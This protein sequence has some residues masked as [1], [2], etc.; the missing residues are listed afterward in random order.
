MSTVRIT[1]VPSTLLGQKRRA[2]IEHD[3]GR[4][5]AALKRVR[6]CC[7]HERE[8]SEQRDGAHLVAAMGADE[9]RE[10]EDECE[11][12]RR[13]AVMYKNESIYS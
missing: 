10:Q 1:P 11:I 13:D 7:D 2:C 5:E 4:L 9:V 8:R 3:L 12:A 6:P